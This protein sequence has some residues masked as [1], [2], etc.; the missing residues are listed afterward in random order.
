MTTGSTSDTGTT[1]LSGS[2]S[3]P[4]FKTMRYIVDS[5]MPI[6]LRMYPI[7]M[8]LCKIKIENKRNN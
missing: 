6:F 8:G 1:L 3:G 4:V 5:L 7:I 2:F